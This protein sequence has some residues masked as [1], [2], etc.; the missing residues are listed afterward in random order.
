MIIHNLYFHGDKNIYLDT[1][2]TCLGGVFDD[3]SGTIFSISPK[4]IYTSQKF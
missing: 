1:Q 2:K 3:N 4:K